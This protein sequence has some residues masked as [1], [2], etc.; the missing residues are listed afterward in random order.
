MRQ[1]VQWVKVPSGASGSSTTS[2]SST[3]PAGSARQAIVGVLPAPSQVR[4][5]GI[6]PPSLKSG[7]ENSIVSGAAGS[8]GLASSSSPPP[9]PARAAATN[10]AR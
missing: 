6:A 10:A 4:S 9:Q 2:T 1:A 5:S 8:V 7:V 3:A